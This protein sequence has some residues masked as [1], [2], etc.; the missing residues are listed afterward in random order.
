MRPLPLF[1]YTSRA[2]STSWMIALCT[3]FIVASFS[4]A[5]GLQSSMDTLMDNFSSEYYIV[6]RQSDSGPDLF[7]EGEISSSV[8]HA[9]FGLFS[10]TSTEPGNVSTIAFCVA[11]DYQVLD[12]TLSTGGSDVLAGTGLPLSG[13]VTLEAEGQVGATIV[14]KYSS[15]VFPSDWLL[16]SEQLMR[17]LLATSDSTF[18]FAVIASPSSEEQSLLTDAGFVVQ[19]M[20][21]VLEFL[22]SGSQELRDDALLVLLPS[23][24]VVGV[25]VYSFLGSEVADRRREIGILKTI[26]AGRTRL[27]SYL[28]TNGLLITAWGA[29]LGLA[30]GIILSYGIATIAS[31]LYPSVFVIEIE[32]GL[33][34]IAYCATLVAGLVGTMIPAIRSTRTSPM[35]DLK[36]V[37]RF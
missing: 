9:A 1:K 34:V 11:D 19:P 28:M 5:A 14:G 17:S 23:S 35:E 2:R 24:F 13:N 3:M 31:H 16:C 20:I 25:L 21:A 12:E 33:L 18:N 6:T 30:L 29:A 37:G 8:E 10:K 4:V 15:S 36:E 27:F 26:G 22:E 7:D 32:E